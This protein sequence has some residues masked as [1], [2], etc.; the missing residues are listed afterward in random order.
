[1]HNS[2]TELHTIDTFAEKNN[3]TR[4]SAINKI[5]QL[6]KKNLVKVSGGGKQKRLYKIFDKPED[7]TMGFYDVVNKY[8]PEKLHPAFRHIVTGRYTIERAII[9]G[10]LM[11]E[12]RTKEAIKYL[13]WHVTDWKLLIQLA[14][15][16][17][18]DKELQNIYK[19]ARK[20]TRVRKMPKRYYKDD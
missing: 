7:E 18:L 5:V 16:F 14:K 1:M 10:L 20:I 4:K 11:N 19:D 3:I 12:Y 2:M 6:K 15:K 17:S 9:E 8:S 13:F